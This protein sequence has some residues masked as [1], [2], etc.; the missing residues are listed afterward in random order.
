MRFLLLFLA[1]LAAFGQPPR[2]F[3]QWWDS[4]V[5]RDLQL[6]DDQYK[7]IHSTVRD[8]RNRLIDLRAAVEKA[9]NDV[10]DLLNED[11]PDP[12]RSA[13]VINRLV[14]ARGDL[15]RAYTELSVKLRSSLTSQQWRELQRR[16]PMAPPPPPPAPRSPQPARAPARVPAPP[17]APPQPPEP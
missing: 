6:T 17:P 16:R 15:T 12:K 14:A 7:Q 13:D 9:D 4:P 1:S 10:E 2:G 5:V 3:F 11:K 8:Y